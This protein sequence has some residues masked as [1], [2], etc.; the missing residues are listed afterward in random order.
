MKN[1]FINKLIF[2]ISFIGIV[3]IWSKLGFCI[4]VIMLLILATLC[5]LNLLKWIN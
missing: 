5:K 1:E 2:Y 4:P 3:I